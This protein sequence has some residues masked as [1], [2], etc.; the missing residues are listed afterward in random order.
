MKFAVIGDTHFGY[1]FGGKR[2]NESFIN[3]FEAFELAISE[4]VDFII[5]VGDF[6]D[7]RLPKPEVISPVLKKLS[8]YNKM[9]PKVKLTETIDEKN[10]SILQN[11][12]IPP[13]IVIL[14]DHDRRPR[15]FVNP[16]QLLYDANL[17]HYIQS[18]TEVVEVNEKRIAIHGFSNVPHQNA[19]EIFLKRNF[20]KIP[21]LKNILLMHQNFKEMI[22]NLPEDMLSISDIPSFYDASFLGHIHWKKEFRNK[23]SNNP[24][25]FTGSTVATQMTKQESKIKKGIFIVDLKDELIINFKELKSPR[26]LKYINLNIDNMKPSEINVKINE[27]IKEIIEYHNHPLIPMIRIKLDGI[28]HDGFL[29]S[30]INFKTINKKFEDKLI[31]NID[32]SKIKSKKLEEKTKLIRKAK[33]D[34]KNINQL[35]IEILS[36]KMN[37]RDIQK[38]EEIFMLLKT[39]NLDE[40]LTKI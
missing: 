1:N 18:E 33:N 15:D 12:K 4:N 6:F 10:K 35:G 32:K 21:N 36:K 27:S 37:I 7:E 16:V 24:I 38:I 19:K 14:G 17:I 20:Q 22:P 26:V 29:P 2:K 3:G 30:D 13:I 5:Q 11:K 39:N 34:K 31:L 28:L 25:I 23:I 40:V 8:E 9:I